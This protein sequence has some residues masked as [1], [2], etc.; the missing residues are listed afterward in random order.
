MDLLLDSHV[1]IWSIAADPRLPPHVSRAIEDSTNSLFVSTA[2]LW[3]LSIKLAQSR[4]RL[5]AGFDTILEFLERWNI[6]LLPVTLQHI[7]AAAA[8][9]FHHGDPFDRMLIAQANTEHLRLVSGDEKMRL[10]A[11]DILW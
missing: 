2:S 5:A 3:E 6:Q 4:L 7:R 11:V 10:Y 1:L 8:L 9:P